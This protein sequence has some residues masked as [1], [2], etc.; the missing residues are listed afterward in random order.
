MS[1]IGFEGAVPEVAPDAFVAPGVVL[2][3]AVRLGAEASVWFGS[4]IRA[5]IERIEIGA[6]SNIQDGCVLHADPGRPVSIGERVSIGHRAVVH[7]C[8]IG[9]DVLVGMGAVV[10]NG[11]V[12][13]SGSLVAAGAVVREGAEIPPGSLVAGVPATVRR[14]VTDA[15]VER[16]RRNA[17]AYL[18]LARR[19]RRELGGA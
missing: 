12:V 14:P 4:V 9:D 1:L 6:G 15:E 17:V 11:A 10:L 7:G 19:Y 16:V 13:G 3:G 8:T 5:D 2:V 18:D